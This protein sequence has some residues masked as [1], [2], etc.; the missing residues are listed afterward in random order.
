M[1]RDVDCT[2]SA[3][4]HHVSRPYQQQLANVNK[5]L[6]GCCRDSATCEPLD[7]AKVQNS[8]VFNVPDHRILPSVSG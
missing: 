2:T 4:N 7:A 1:N 3:V 8:T 6:G 5:K